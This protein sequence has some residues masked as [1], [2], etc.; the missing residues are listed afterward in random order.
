[1]N[2]ITSKL[3]KDRYQNKTSGNGNHTVATTEK[4]IELVCLIARF[5]L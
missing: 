4:P 5:R 2:A 1:M 3:V